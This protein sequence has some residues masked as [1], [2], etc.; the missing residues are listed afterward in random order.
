MPP[1]RSIVKLNVYDM[2]WINDYA[3]VLGVGVYH[4][5]VEIHGVGMFL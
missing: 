1:P 5:G 4:S 3:S 2:Y